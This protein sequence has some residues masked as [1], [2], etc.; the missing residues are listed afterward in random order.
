MCDT[1][2]HEQVTITQRAAL[3]RYHEAELRLLDGEGAWQL[4]A[5][6]HGSG[7]NGSSTAGGGAA[8][9]LGDGSDALGGDNGGVEELLLD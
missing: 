2:C 5:I 9:G 3:L 8:A 6:E 7:G 1:F 4:R